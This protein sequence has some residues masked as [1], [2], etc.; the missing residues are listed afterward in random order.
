MWQAL[1]WDAWFD[2][3][4]SADPAPSDGLAPFHTDDAG[5]LWTSDKGR[6]WR[7][8]NYQYDDLKDMPHTPDD[9]FK[10]RLRQNVKKLYPTASAHV[11]ASP[12]LTTSHETF[13]DYII[14]VVYD[15][16]ALGGRAYAILF[17]LG[18]PQY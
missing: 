3:P 16:L 11:E 13:N 8:S 2:K 6:D 4:H 9:A 18:D 7:K 14:N 1:N 17:Y 10:N 12:G 5:H 15:R